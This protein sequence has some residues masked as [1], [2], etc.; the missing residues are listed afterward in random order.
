M[1]RKW[2]LSNLKSQ[3]LLI[4]VFY[5]INITALTPWVIFKMSLFYFEGIVCIILVLLR[6]KVILV[7]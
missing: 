1:R 5:T 6:N 3:D 2:V 4:S 7:I